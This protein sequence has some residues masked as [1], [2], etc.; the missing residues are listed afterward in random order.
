MTRSSI[1][2][3]CIILA[4]TACSS[5]PISGGESSPQASELTVFA[6]SSLTKGF[7][8]L[9]AD[10]EAAHPGATVTFNF[11]PSDGLAAQIDSEGGADV[12]ASASQT[13]MDDVAGKA[14]ITGRTDFVTNELVIITPSDDPAGIG[15]LDDL[16]SPGVQ[17][18]LAA[19][20]VPV[21]DYA[22]EAL[23]NA[24]IDGAVLANVVSN[25]ED[26]AAVVATIIS[27][28]AD[29]GIVYVSDVTAEVA[30][31]VR[32]VEIPDDV[33]VIATYPIAIVDGSSNTELAQQ[34]V[35]FV[36]TGDGQTRLVGEFGFLP[37]A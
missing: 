25:A 6:G 13:W 22:R 17:V 19:E 16:A 5:A 34:W 14:G 36:T 10:F 20:G 2:G 35:H 8:E 27:G 12:F 30:P 32:S 23:T 31:G 9:G 37:A 29:A 21:G 11:G 4:L 28:E 26:D 1:A 3:T 33:N 15:S 7:T 24:K 18:V